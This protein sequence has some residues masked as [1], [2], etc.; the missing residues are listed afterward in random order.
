[1]ILQRL[2]RLQAK[3]VASELQDSSYMILR[4]NR[5]SVGTSKDYRSLSRRNMAGRPF[6]NHLCFGIQ[7]E[8]AIVPPSIDTVLRSI[9]RR[10]TFR[11]IQ[12]RGV[13]FDLDQALGAKSTVSLLR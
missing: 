8:P 2:A 5:P 9:L 4:K 1:L 11:F 3:T 7:N 12:G 13:G 10:V 6:W